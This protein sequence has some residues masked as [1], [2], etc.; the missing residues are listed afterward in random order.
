MA[1][2]PRPKHRT[3]TDAGRTSVHRS[4]PLKPPGEIVETIVDHL[5]SSTYSRSEIA[6]VVRLELEHLLPWQI[7]GPP[8]FGKLA[9]NKKHAKEID[10]LIGKL[11]ETLEETPKG[12]ANS[13]FILASRG[14]PLKWSLHDPHSPAVKHFRQTLL[15]GLAGLRRACSDIM[16]PGNVVGDHHNRDRVKQLCAGCALD[17]IVGLDAGEP[18]NS[19][20]NSPLRVIAGVL[21]GTVGPRPNRKKT[22]SGPT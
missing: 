5:R 15:A 7:A 12:T 14:E 2:A 1:R 20:E 18:T 22:V 9:E 4:A 10:K 17:L 3:T 19:S 16:A 13:L 8:I 11:L 6:A 21:Y